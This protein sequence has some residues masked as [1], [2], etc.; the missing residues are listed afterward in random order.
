MQLD[1]LLVLLPY[2]EYYLHLHDA[3][4]CC[5]LQ[6]IFNKGVSKSESYSSARRRFGFGTS[7]TWPG[8]IIGVAFG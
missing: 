3:F 7:D 4:V 6:S 5:T 1:P 2:A 8:C